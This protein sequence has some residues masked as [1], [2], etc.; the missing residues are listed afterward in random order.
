MSLNIISL[1]ARGLRDVNKRRAVFKFYR[2]RCD[3]LCLQETHSTPEDESVWR[4]EWGGKSFFSHGSSA[5]RG[6]MILIKKGF[7]GKCIHETS[8]ADERNIVI[9]ITINDVTMC[10]CSIYAPNKDSPQFF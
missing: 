8:S 5:A 1:N 10:I 2:D 9:N 7:K 3:V 4:A 6:T